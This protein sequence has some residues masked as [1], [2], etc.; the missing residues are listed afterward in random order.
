MEQKPKKT[1]RRTLY[2]KGVIKEAFLTA[3]KTKPYD[4]IMVSDLCKAAEINRSTFYL[5]YTDALAVFDEILD[6]LLERITDEID[7]LVEKNPGIDIKEI[8]KQGMLLQNDLLENKQTVLI[9]TKGFSYPRFVDRF[10]EHLAVK[11]LVP[12]AKN[13]SALSEQELLLL[14]KSIMYAFVALGG[15]FMQT[16]KLKELSDYIELLGDYMFTPCLEK[17]MKR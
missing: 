15:N 14:C 3:L 4:K 5:H 10:S 9:M 13:S 6:E 8:L 16:H 12:L 7:A 1:D 2:T 11:M 17:L